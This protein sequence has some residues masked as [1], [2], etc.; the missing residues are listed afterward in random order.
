VIAF[1]RMQIKG[2][3]KLINGCNDFASTKIAR[4]FEGVQSARN[5]PQILSSVSTEVPKAQ[6]TQDFEFKAVSKK[7]Q[8]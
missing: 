5:Q 6:V 7:L 2:Q 8:M 1:K 4:R 3:N